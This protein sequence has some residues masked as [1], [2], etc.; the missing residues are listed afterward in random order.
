MAIASPAGVCPPFKA[1]TGTPFCSAQ[2]TAD[3]FREAYQCF[4]SA[5]LGGKKEAHY[6]IGLMLDYG[7]GIQSNPEKAFENYLVAARDGYA[8]AQF[9]LGFLYE[10]GRGTR[11]LLSEAYV[12]YTLAG[13][14]GMGN[15]VRT[16]NELARKMQPYEVAYAQQRLGM[17]KKL[18]AGE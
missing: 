18:L 12:W 2:P 11:K 17:L 7:Q 16:R 1:T 3:N 9:N 13:E 4:S 6:Y 14:S 15:A 10:S 8:R 5:A